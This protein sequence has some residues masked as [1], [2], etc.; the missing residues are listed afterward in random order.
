[1][2]PIFIGVAGGS[3]A[4][5]SSLCT[6]LMDKYPDQ[7]GLI[8][9]DDYFKPSGQVPILDG[10]ENWDHPDSLFLDKLAADLGTLGEG[11][12][13]TINTKNERLNPYYARTDKRIP[14]VFVPKPLMLVEGYLALYD[15]S[16]RDQF[17]EAIWL[18][19][20]HETRWA[21]RVHFKDGVYAEKVLKPMHALFVEPTK[22]FAT[23]M[24]DVSG[25]GKDEV[26]SR[27]ETHLQ[28]FLRV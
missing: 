18:E 12:P 2:K 14:V 27:V 22:K 8:Q 11:N 23:W 16:V 15:K 5:K 24:L 26:L 28:R 25:L 1:M 13:V 21:R 7:I 17:T 4:G 19:V 9:L 10:L 20:D 3:G 6:A